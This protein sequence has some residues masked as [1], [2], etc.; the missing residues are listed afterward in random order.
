MPR[1]KKALSETSDLE[2]IKSDKEE[3]NIPYFLIDDD[4]GIACDE[5]QEILVRKRIANRTIKDVNK[6]YIEQYVSWDSLCY[7]SN[8]TN[9]I[10]CYVERKG[11]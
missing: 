11:R 4:Y 8:F 7:P 2:I 9:A 5:R 10:S 6:E 1:G 3:G